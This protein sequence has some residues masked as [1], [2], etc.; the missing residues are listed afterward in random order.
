MMGF[1]RKHVTNFAKPVYSLT[2]LTHK[3]VVFIWTESCRKPIDSITKN[4]TLV[5]IQY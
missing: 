4:N 3:R 1:N 5:L 2:E